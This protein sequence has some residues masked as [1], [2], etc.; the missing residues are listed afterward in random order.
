MLVEEGIQGEDM[1][2]PEE[3]EPIKGMEDIE[4]EEDSNKD[5]V[6][7]HSRECNPSTLE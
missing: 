6:D 3:E 7:I 2:D 5:K 1:V 4:D